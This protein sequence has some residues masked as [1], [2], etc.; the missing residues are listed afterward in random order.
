MAQRGPPFDF[1]LNEPTP[2][3]EDDGA[4]D[5][6]GARAPE[7]M[8]EPSPR[9]LLPPSPL[10]T[11]PPPQHDALPS[12]EP[13]PRDPLPAPSPEPSPRDPLPAAVPESSPRDPL[14]SPTHE[15][16][17]RDPLH[18]PS[19]VLDLEAPLSSLDDEDDYDYDEEELPPPPPLPPFGLPNAAAPAR[20]SSSVDAPHAL[21]VRPN[22]QGEPLGDTARLSSPENSAPRGP[23][24][25]ASGTASSHRSRRRPYS[26]DP[27]DDDAISKQRR[28]DNYDDDARSSRSGNR[29]SGCPRRYERSELASPPH[30]E[31]GGGRRAPGTHGPPGAPPR[32]RRRQRRPQHGYHQY[33]GPIQKQQGRGREQPQGFRGQERQQAHQGHHEVPKVGYSSYDPLSGSF[34]RWGSPDDDRQ[35][36]EREPFDG[37]GGYHQRR[38]APPFRQS[39]RPRGRE[40]SCHGRQN[41]AQEPPKT[42]GYHQRWEAPSL[43][44]SSAHGRDSSSGGRKGPP[45]QP[46]NGGAYQQRKAPRGGDHFPDRPYHPYARDGGA[47]DR[48]NGGHQARREPPPNYEYRRDSKQRPS[49]GGPSR[50][51]QYYGD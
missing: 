21:P 49:G 47:S 10:D 27:R 50:D 46:I 44:P 26:Y 29:R 12:P 18:P 4:A 36:P 7:P 2:P 8:R 3:E 14:P 25:S 41:Q 51:R 28:V 43:R 38:E 6:S 24:R 19:P 15:P 48:A 37:N 22:G 1:D 23:S 16:S 31:Q 20:S 17:P 35:S 40:D 42:G 5:A 34:V 13:S 45:Q 33:P 9:D 30:Y 39:S 32:N 11:L